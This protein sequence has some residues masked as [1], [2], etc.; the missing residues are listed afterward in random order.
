MKESITQEFD[1]GCAIAC[2][3]FRLGIM[4]KETAALVGA[5]QANSTRF[6]IKDLTH[7]LNSI[8]QSYRSIHVK[9]KNRRSIYEEG[10]IVL[11]R[12]SKLYPSGHYLIR[13]KGH[14][15]D[16]WI[17]MPYEKD[18]SKAKSGFRKRLPGDPMYAILPVS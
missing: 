2:I 12:R 13:H 11:I 9:P 14:W 6:Y 5:K 8:G 15:M 17:N 16:P 4:Y 7:F 1:Y 3:S 10:T 18:I